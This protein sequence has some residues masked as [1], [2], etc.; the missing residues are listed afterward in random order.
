MY[1]FLMKEPEEERF[2]Q[3]GFNKE[4]IFFRLNQ[5]FQN[6]RIFRIRFLWFSYCKSTI[7]RSKF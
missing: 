6:V 3:K 7:K 2:L 5:D 4:K 1:V